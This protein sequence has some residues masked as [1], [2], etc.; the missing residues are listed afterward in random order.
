MMG[1]VSTL[2]PSWQPVPVAEVPDV[3]FARWRGWTNVHDRGESIEYLQCW[4]ARERRSARLCYIV[5]YNTLTCMF[6]SEHCECAQVVIEVGADGTV[7]ANDGFEP[8]VKNGWL[9]GWKA[10]SSDRMSE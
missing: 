1:D 5:E 4:A 6:P 9:T 8:V 7:T 10:Q 3:D 2:L